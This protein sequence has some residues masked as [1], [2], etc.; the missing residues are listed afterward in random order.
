MAFFKKLPVSENCDCAECGIFYKGPGAWLSW[1]H[2]LVWRW[3]TGRDVQAPGW[4]IS[5]CVQKSIIC[6]G[7]DGYTL[8]LLSSGL[9]QAG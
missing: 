1:L 6:K 7:K 5:L 8:N 9:E 4:F 3:L 2:H